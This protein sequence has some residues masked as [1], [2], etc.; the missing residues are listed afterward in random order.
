MEANP[1]YY[2]KDHRPLVN[3]HPLSI[4]HGTLSHWQSILDVI[5]QVLALPAGVITRALP[6]SMEIAVAARDA[7]NPFNPGDRMEMVGRYCEAVILEKQ[8]LHVIDART[9]PYWE[10]APEVKDYGLV[11]YIG[12]PLFWPDGEMFGTLCMMSP[13]PFEFGTVHK[14]L[15]Y[16]FKTAV[17]AHLASVYI[18]AQVKQIDTELMNARSEIETLQGLLQ[19]HSG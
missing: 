7:D 8:P 10:N 12:Y 4:P 14:Q 1:H 18:R 11:A 19:K 17:E 2:K 3:V 5:S 6:P 15:I 9:D 13:E 16:E